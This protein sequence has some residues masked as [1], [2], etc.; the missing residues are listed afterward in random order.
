MPFAVAR[1]LF[2]PLG[3]GDVNTESMVRSVHEAGYRGWYV[4]E[5]DTA[6]GEHSPDDVPRRDTARSLAYLD[7]VFSRLRVD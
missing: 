2:V 5:Q 3:D 7:Q 1:G 4:L 6:L